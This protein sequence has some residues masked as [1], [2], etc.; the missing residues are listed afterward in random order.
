MLTS[1]AIVIFGSMLLEARRASR[2]ER[3]QRAR[4]GIEP[5]DDVYSLMRAAYPAAFA[6]M[7]AEGLARGAAAP[8]LVAAGAIT[9]A[10]A[11]ALKWWAIRSLGSS[12]T[13]RVIAVPGSPLVAK[14]PYRMLRHPNYVAVAG[15]LIGVAL[16]TGAA[17]AGP[18]GTATFGAL[19][20]K[21]IAVEERAL[22][23]TAH[24]PPA[25]SEREGPERS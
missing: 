11:K 2:N 8:V 5:E 25:A 4:G 12:W 20:L 7:L 9:F 16:M 19:L 10:V 23:L 6:A 15:E 3:L 22:G 24:R 14:G 18:A 13:F 17:V 1:L 21:R